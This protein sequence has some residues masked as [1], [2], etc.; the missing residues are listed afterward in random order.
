MIDEQTKSAI[1]A[2]ADRLHDPAPSPF[3]TPLPKGPATM[4][5]FQQHEYLFALLVTLALTA[6]ASIVTRFGDPDGDPSTPPPRF[7]RVLL[8]IADVLS[9]LPLPGK[10]G[11]TPRVN[12]P[13]LPSREAPPKSEG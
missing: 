8:V 1:L 2:L 4:E 11:V 7:V 6:I 13:G 9:W 3:L 12:L 5:F 10:V